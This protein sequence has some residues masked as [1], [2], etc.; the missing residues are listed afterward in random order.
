MLDTNRVTDLP[1][2][3]GDVLGMPAD[4]I[5]GAISTLVQRRQFSSLVSQIHR[6]FQSSDAALRESGARALQKL[7]FPI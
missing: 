5:P 7:G 1:Q 6:D 2:K 3:T 4:A